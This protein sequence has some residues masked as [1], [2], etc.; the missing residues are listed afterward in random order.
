VFGDDVSL[1]H[2][3]GAAVLLLSATSACFLA[4]RRQPEDDPGPPVSPSLLRILRNDH[5]SRHPHGLPRGLRG[6]ERWLP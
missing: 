6:A 3:L 1:A 5:R 4:A 2:L